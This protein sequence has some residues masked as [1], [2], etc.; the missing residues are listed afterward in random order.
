[1]RISRKVLAACAAAVMAVTMSATA[2]AA[3]MKVS[4]DEVKTK[5]VEVSVPMI[6][7]ARGG[8]KVDEKVNMTL[9]G[10]SFNAMESFISTKKP[11]EAANEAEFVKAF[12]N[13]KEAK[14]DVKQLAAYL[15][16]RLEKDRLQ[17][18]QKEPYYVHI[19][20]Q[21]KSDPTFDNLFLSVVQKVISYTGGAHSNEVS[22]PVNIDLRTGKTA[23]LAD[24][25][26]PGVDYQSR[27]MTLMKIQAKGEQRIVNEVEKAANLKTQP[28]GYYVPKTIT[29]N[30]KF[31][32]NSKVG[33]ITVF[34]D[35]G[36]IAPISAGT[37]S[38]EFSL[39]DIA[40]IIRLGK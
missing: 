37:R 28:E 21:M 18:G 16:G 27:L 19:F 24:M 15:N 5:G 17:V 10:N 4:K 30:E 13:S 32:T 6:T 1:M 3:A 25:F 9:L 34:Y 26:T 22:L 36:E 23:T 12:K 35:P 40:D 29:G 11:I 39:A 33:S 2:F 7:G 38:F 14:K 8:S 31:Y 20:Y